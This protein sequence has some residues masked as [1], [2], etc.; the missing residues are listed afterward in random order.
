M[1]EYRSIQFAIESV[2]AHCQ[3]MIS[4]LL[5]DVV[6]AE[7]ERAAAFEIKR[8]FEDMNWKDLVSRSVKEQIDKL[9]IKELEKIIESKVDGP[10]Y[11]DGRLMG[12]ADVCAE[13]RAILDP[14]DAHQWN[15]DGLLKEVRRIVVKLAKR[16]K[17]EPR[18][19]P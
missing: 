5:G 19:T 4:D 1:P 15:M 12:H 8:S 11:S 9:R 18:I 3:E 16:E 7:L 14:K 17:I 10:L 2:Q 6:R 13:L